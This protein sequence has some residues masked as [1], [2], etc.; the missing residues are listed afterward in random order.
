METTFE[1]LEVRSSVLL[2]RVACRGRVGQAGQVRS[3]VARR[4]R[5]RPALETPDS[6]RATECRVPVRTLARRI[7]KW[8]RSVLGPANARSSGFG[9]SEGSFAVNHRKATI[10]TG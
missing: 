8:A 1:C 9:R 6:R 10:P 2:L 7:Q 4:L 3:T 5:C